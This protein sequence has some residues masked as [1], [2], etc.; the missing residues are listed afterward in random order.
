MENN[1]LIIDLIYAL[2]YLALTG[3][4]A[5]IT[6]LS[7]VQVKAAII[8]VVPVL[9]RLFD[10]N[11]ALSRW[12]KARGIDPATADQAA[13]VVAD[14]LEKWSAAQREAQPLPERDNA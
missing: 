11:T 9:R 8:E 4:V 12:L 14:A 13:E 10:P 5:Y 6:K 3:A 1:Q 7:A 2:V